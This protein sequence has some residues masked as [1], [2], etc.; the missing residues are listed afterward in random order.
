MKKRLIFLLLIFIS[1]NFNT[2]AVEPLCIEDLNNGQ[3]I[4]D[5]TIKDYCLEARKDKVATLFT[6]DDPASE[7]IKNFKT[8]AEFNTFLNSTP[9][10]VNAGPW[11]FSLYPDSKVNKIGY[12]RKLTK[13]GMYS[14]EGESEIKDFLGDIKNGAARYQTKLVSIQHKNIKD[15]LNDPPD[16]SAD[17]KQSEASMLAVC[18][19]YSVLHAR[20]CAESL[21][22]I[23]TLM[24]PRSNIMIVPIMDKVLSDSSYQAG[25]AKAAL[26][27]MDRVKNGN[28]NGNLFDDIKSSFK[29]VGLKDLDAEDHAWNL[30]AVWA[31]RGPNT[32]FLMPYSNHN[33]YHTILSLDVISSAIPYLDSLAIENGLSAYSYPPT[34]KTKCSYGKSY[35]FWMSAFL[36]REIS[37]QTGDPVG[38]MYAAYL[39]EIGYQMKSKTNG[40]DPA[41]V[42]MVDAHDVANNKLR[43]DVAFGSAGAVYGMQ[44][45]S[46]KSLGTLQIDDAISEM[47]KNSNE[48]TK[49]NRI[50]AD[51]LWTGTG[52]EGYFR[53]K[54]IMA[55]DAGLDVLLKD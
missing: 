25:S 35:H 48:K 23:S 9:E 5:K 27:I 6:Y 33:N 22:K 55:P 47:I 44:I 4:V 40:R 43:I 7:D 46:N 10:K 31:A 30:I 51:K 54:S 15:L 32:D 45:A 19:T 13:R 26:K 14:F 37:K 50:E 42:F 38:A 11:I 53:W 20:K 52:M 39:A 3:A 16:Q 18:A 17:F 41:R 36:T 24:S 28:I 29:E 8:D 21:V 1:A 34:V 49:L 12:T 2:F